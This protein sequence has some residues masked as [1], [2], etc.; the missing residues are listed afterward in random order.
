MSLIPLGRTV[1]AILAALIAIL[2]YVAGDIMGLFS[3]KNQFNVDGRTVLLTGGSQGMGKGLAKILAEKGANVVI[4]ARNQANL[5]ATLAYI[6][7]AAKSPSQRFHAISA[8]VTNP[9]ESI[10]ILTETTAWNNGHPPDVVW[11]N[12]G[13]A[14]LGM[15]A[16]MPISTLRAQ[17]DLNYWGAAYLSHAA[18]NLFLGRTGTNTTEQTHPRHIVMTSSV[19]AFVGL[20]G[21]GPYG[22]AKA[23]MRN[24]ADTLRSE[25][26]L[27]NGARKGSA[28]GQAPDRDIK[29]HIVLPATI[30]SPGYEN[31][32]LTKP[33]VTKILEET[34]P[35]QTEDQVA[36]AA[37]AGLEK[38]EFMI[39]TL[40]L[41]T[42]MR[43]SMLGG[44][45]RNNIVT[46]TL[47][48]WLA[49]IVWLFVGPDMD[50]KV[51]N[52]GKKNGMQR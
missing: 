25:V 34:D 7:K 11:A 48:S 28:K 9:D 20:P 14:S 27:Y 24:L 31:E 45:K 26:L 21:Y 1:T 30:L 47:M 42:L 32:E 12:A 13:S 40:L 49:S 8:D 52:Y 19:G 22:P 36:T 3:R 23:A 41:G 29:V 15:F 51:W 16:D 5:D 33:A 37:I 6:S 4:V 17:M 10:R 44:T 46:D 50:G 43:T 18:L 2:I 38:G 35:K 39:T